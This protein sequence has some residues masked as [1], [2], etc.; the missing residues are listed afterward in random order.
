MIFECALVGGFRGVEPTE[1]SECAQRVPPAWLADRFG[2]RECE[3]FRVGV[4]EEPA[5]V[6]LAL[7]FNELDRF[8]HARVGLPTG[9]AEIIERAE[10]V[11]VVAGR[12]SELEEFGIRDFAGRAAAVERAIEEIPFSA[13][14]G[15]RD[16]VRV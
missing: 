14:A 13:A 15:S 3:R 5:A 16:F 9:C 10:D 1:D 4:F 2:K 6:G 7:A 11:V 12:E 8:G